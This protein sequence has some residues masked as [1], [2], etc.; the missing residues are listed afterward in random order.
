[1]TT[2]W[3]SASR[4]AHTV[5]DTFAPELPVTSEFGPIAFEVDPSLDVVAGGTLAL[6][7][8]IKLDSSATPFVI[9]DPPANPDL[10][11][12]VAESERRV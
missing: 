1:M 10:V 7:F 8:G 12:T 3:W 2:R 5:S 9:V 6:G 4:S 11:K